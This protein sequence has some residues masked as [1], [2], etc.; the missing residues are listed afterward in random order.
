M[1]FTIW[2]DADGCP[3]E[4]REV[5]FRASAR[6]ELPVRLVANSALPVPASPLI[7]SVVVSHGLDGA[8]SYIAEAVSTGDV[9]VTSDVP[10]AARVVER[11]AVAIDHRG[12]LYDESNVG[13]R[14]SV[15]NF[16]QG[17]R[18]GGVV[19]G[20]PAAF[21]A[22]DKKRFAATLDRLLTRRLRESSP[23]DTG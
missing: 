4:V 16:L 1:S 10:L 18:S 9:V 3:G 5:V 17:L 8:D 20:G 19:V 11:G 23:G 13:E 22:A 12:E 15:R 2:I 14:L 6:L 21:T 7:S